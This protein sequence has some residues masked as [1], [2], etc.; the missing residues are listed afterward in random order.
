MEDVKT[1]WVTADYGAFDEDAAFTLSREDDS[2][3]MTDGIYGYDDDDI[4]MDRLFDF[5]RVSSD[6]E[7]QAGG[8]M[9]IP[10][11]EMPTIK[12][13]SPKKPD[14]ANRAKAA[15]QKTQITVSYH[16]IDYAVQL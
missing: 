15:N 14:E 13:N 8:S 7:T 5:E 10:S 3:V 2:S 1:K 11:P 6:P 9:N 4:S 12:T 16:C